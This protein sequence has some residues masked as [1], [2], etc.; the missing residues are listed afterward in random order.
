MTT[1]DALAAAG[2]VTI[3]VGLW[4]AWPPVAIIFAGAVLFGTA[5]LLAYLRRGRAAEEHH[6]G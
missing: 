4:S 1:I 6:E 5:V 3:F 2:V